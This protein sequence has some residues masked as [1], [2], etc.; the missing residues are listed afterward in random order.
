VI[1]AVT[2]RRERA[3]TARP[4]ALAVIL[5]PG[6]APGVVFGVA[7]VV[8]FGVALGALAAPAHAQNEK[9]EPAAGAPA[10]GAAGT[11]GAAT[12]TAAGA[13][14]GAEDGS[15]A[16]VLRTTQMC[17]DAAIANRLAVKRQRRKAVDRLF[18]KQARH[19]LS[20]VGGYYQ[21]DLFSGT[22]VA[23]GSYT[24]H[25]TENTAVEFGAAYTHANA[26]V[27]RAIEDGRANILDDDF[28]RVLL[29]ESLLMWS[30]IYGKLRLGGS[31]VR[32]DINAGLGVGIAEAETS[33]GAAGVA[34]L[35]MKIFIGRALAF[36][37]DAR[38]HV[39]QQELLD[40]QF[41]VKD[42]SITSGLSLFLPMR[43]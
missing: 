26:D 24:Y 19:E 39:F 1:R 13:E 29:V 9:A 5:A 8:A 6:V 34:G 21:S 25:M 43:N 33:R 23:G 14:T 35:G 42:L 12:D 15:G 7:F 31:V 10:T 3:R 40:E 22:Y 36:R 18:V 38:N 2:A 41:L 17:I 16:P 4:G 28:D 20:A 30:P 37:I 32:F 27:I 11:T